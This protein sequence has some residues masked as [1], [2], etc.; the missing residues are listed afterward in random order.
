MLEG[1]DI[2][3]YSVAGDLQILERELAAAGVTLQTAAM[4]IVDP[5]RLWQAREPR[6]LTDAYRRFVGETPDGLQAH[7]ALDDLRMT[8]AVIERMGAERTAAQLR[9]E[10]NPHLVDPA[11]RF[12][13]DEQRRIVF[14]F[15][16]HRGAPASE[17]PDFLE[18][19]LG[20]DFP[21]STLAIAR[22][23]LERSRTGQRDD[24]RGAGAEPGDRTDDDVPF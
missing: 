6:K 4:R 11:G 17:H 15:G 8:V 10:G 19:M 24:G 22:Q 20:K 3:G 7:D 16:Q 9:A 23:A 2:A 12:R 5:L 13:L 14:A 21:P 1:A 18:W